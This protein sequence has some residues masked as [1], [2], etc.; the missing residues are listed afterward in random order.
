MYEIVNI[1]DQ[2]LIDDFLYQY[3]NNMLQSK[4]G[5]V[6]HGYSNKMSS[7]HRVVTRLRAEPKMNP[8]FCEILETYIGDGSIVNQLDFLLYREGDFFLPHSDVIK[9]DPFRTWTTVTMLDESDD[10]EG[11]SL[12]LYRDFGTEP[13]HRIWLKNGETIIFKSDVIHEAA[14]VE[15]GYRIVM[16]AWLHKSLDK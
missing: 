4:P 12:N 10:L 14:K 11:G 7:S 1:V 3:R 9:T 2:D 15:K 8:E 16:V 5:E 13:E 6:A